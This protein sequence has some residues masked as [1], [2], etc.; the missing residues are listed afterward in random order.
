MS[1]SRGSPKQVVFTGAALLALWALSWGLSYVA[2]GAAAVPVALG[3]AVA[4]AVLVALVFMELVHERA[5]VVVAFATA[6][7][8]AMIL[9][10]LTSADVLTRDRAPLAVPGDEANGG[11]ADL[12]SR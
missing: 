6:L 11:P 1:A 9:V 3:I 7:V 10:G 12:P 5:S 8:L 4:K 2:L